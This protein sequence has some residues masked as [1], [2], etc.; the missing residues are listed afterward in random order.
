MCVIDRA[1]AKRGLAC[2]PQDSH[3][4]LAGNGLKFTDPCPLTMG[5]S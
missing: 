1:N 4:Q 5:S 2:C 3:K